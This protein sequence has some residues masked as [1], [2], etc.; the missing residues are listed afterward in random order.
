[1]PVLP[2]LL[3]AL[4]LGDALPPPFPTV[5]NGEFDASTADWRYYVD[6][7]AGGRLSWDATQGAPTPGSA[8]VGNIFHGARYDSWGQCVKLA[9]GPFTLTASVASQLLAGNRCELRIAVLRS[10]DCNTSAVP[11]L[12]VTAYNVANDGAFEPVSI[13]RTAPATAGAAWIFLSHVRAATA[14]HGDSWCNFD[15]V[16]LVGEAVFASGFDSP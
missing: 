9:P 13:A 12:D 16:K 4:A 11:A 10:A 5:S 8:R 1:M 2:S 7:G 6:S 14:A 15:H 3:L